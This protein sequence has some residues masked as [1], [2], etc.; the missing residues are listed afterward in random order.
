MIEKTNV[1]NYYTL[2]MYE[3]G[4]LGSRVSYWDKKKVN[5]DIKEFKKTYKNS[6]N[7]LS[8]ILLT[9]QFV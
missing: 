4:K 7:S 6:K 9:K 8:L 1:K 3:N 2:E 5:K